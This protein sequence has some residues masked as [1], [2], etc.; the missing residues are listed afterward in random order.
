MCWLR[1]L[2]WRTLREEKSNSTLKQ[3]FLEYAEEMDEITLAEYD[4]D[5]DMIYTRII[6]EKKAKAEAS[7]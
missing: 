1:M 4:E 6:Y 2:L 3:Y 5:D 7:T